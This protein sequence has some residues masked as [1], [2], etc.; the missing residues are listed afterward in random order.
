VATA[1]RELLEGPYYHSQQ[2]DNEKNDCD[3]K[4][5]VNQPACNKTSTETQQPKNE[6]RCGDYQQ[7]CHIE[8]LS[9]TAREASLPS[10]VTSF[11]GASLKLHD[12]EFQDSLGA[13]V[14]RPATPPV[15]DA[16]VSF[17]NAKPSSFANMPSLAYVDLSLCSL[18]SPNSACDRIRV[19]RE[20]FCAEVHIVDGD[21]RFLS[22]DW[23]S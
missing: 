23:H 3:H 9:S 13:Q 12:L 15:D 4:Y 22:R 6:Q 14:L 7:D 2:P 20:T 21:R 1:F 18:G 8:F 11:P 19:N 10:L 5:Y 17:A 16:L